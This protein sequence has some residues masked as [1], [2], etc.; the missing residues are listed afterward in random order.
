MASLKS[1]IVDRAAGNPFFAEELVRTLIEHGALTGDPGTTIRSDTPDAFLPETVQSVLTSRIDRLQEREKLLLQ[2]AAIVGREFLLPVVAE[3]AEL[4]EHVARQA[5]QRLLAAEMI[6]ERPDVQRDAFA[7]RH[8]LVQ[9]VAQTSLLSTH[10]HGCIDERRRPCLA[11]SR[12]EATRWRL[13]L[14]IIGSS[15]A[16]AGKRRQRT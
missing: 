12:N 14:P 10:R 1:R 2:A 11:I 7:F 6:Y 5:T 16:R 4:S 9:E 8:P 15:R 3:I 13:W